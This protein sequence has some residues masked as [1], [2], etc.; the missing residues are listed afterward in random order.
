MT[1]YTLITSIGTGMYK[2][3]GGYR[4]TTY[5]FNDNK[6]YT[7]NLFYEAILKS[8]F[9]PIKK[10]FLSVP[11]HHHGIF[12]LKILM[13]SFGWMYIKGFQIPRKD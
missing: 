10:L 11:V 13:K 6:T 7:T 12:S 1:E 8:N 3:E 9:K 4:E 5:K 2:K